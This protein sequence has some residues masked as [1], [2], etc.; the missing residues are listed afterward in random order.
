MRKVMLAFLLLTA[1]HAAIAQDTDD[2]DKPLSP[3]CGQP[4]ERLAPEPPPPPVELDQPI[5][6]SNP[7]L[8]FFPPETGT[9][10]EEKAAGE[11]CQTDVP[12]P[13]EPYEKTDDASRILAPC[14]IPMAVTAIAGTRDNY[15]LPYDA[16]NLTQGIMNVAG[17]FNQSSWIG[18]DDD[19]TDRHFGHNFQLNFWSLFGYQ[20]GSL[21]ITLRP[22]NHALQSNDTISLWATGAPRGWGVSLAN[23]PY[24]FVRGQET[25]VVLDLRTL[26]TG[27]SN[28][29]ADIS[30]FGDLNVYMQDDTAVDNMVLSMACDLSAAPVPIV[31]VIMGPSGCGGLP[32]YNVFLDNED[33]R[34]ANT[35]GGWIGATV[36]DKNT[37]FRIC[38]ADGRLFTPAATAG[39]NFALISLSPS[40]PTGFTRFDRFHDNEDRRAAS[41]DN[42]PNSSPTFTVQP[43][44]NTNMAFCVATG[45]NPSVAN[46]VFPVLGPSYGVFGGRT[47]ERSPW[48]LDRGFVFL[49]DEDNRNINQPSNP[50]GYTA[51]FLEAGKNTKYY[52]ARAK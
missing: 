30:R 33:N 48:A 39:A 5:D 18:L 37:L 19:R 1:A 45:G 26:A 34:N 15:R 27:T 2:T 23:L 32:A 41:W 17:V 29:L 51:E 47:A 52:M 11:T 31:G 43:E 20:S 38:A 12:A 10:S 3:T 9:V 25:Q 24:R 7:L 36:S 50:P 16:V 40:C 8:G 35:R 42:T 21:M 28:I 49:D 4:S 44:K 13:E 6:M 46:S 22:L 14:A